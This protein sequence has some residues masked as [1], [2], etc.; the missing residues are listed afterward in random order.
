MK[1]SSGSLAHTQERHLTQAWRHAGPGVSPEGFR[2][3]S[4]SEPS[5]TCARR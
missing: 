4:Q 5:D 1:T 2:E 3:M